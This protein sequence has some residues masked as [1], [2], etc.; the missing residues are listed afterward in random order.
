MITRKERFH[1]AVRGGQ[2]DRV[3]MFDFLFEQ[4]MYEAMI[5]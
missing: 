5:G 4:S 1:A 3:P 2:P